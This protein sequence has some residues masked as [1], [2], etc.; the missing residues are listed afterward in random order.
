MGG[1][2]RERERGGKRGRE[3]R[4]R[5]VGHETNTGLRREGRGYVM[6]SGLVCLCSFSAV[7]CDRDK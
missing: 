1:R 4:E 3:G 7:C 5:E 6:V 2:G